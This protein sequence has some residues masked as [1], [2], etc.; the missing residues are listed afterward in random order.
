MLNDTCGCAV[1]PAPVNIPGPQGASAPAPQTGT[2]TLV[3]G[4]VVI[5]AV[6]TSASFIVV[7]RTSSTG[8]VGTLYVTQNVGAGTF[9]VNST[10]NTETSSFQYFIYG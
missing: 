9:T 1:N 7:Q 10:S 2:G 6:L 8:T 5:S 3:A 4:A